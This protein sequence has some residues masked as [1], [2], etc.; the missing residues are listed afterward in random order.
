MFFGN[1]RLN[2]VKKYKIFVI[3]LCFKLFPCFCG[4]KQGLYTCTCAAEF[5]V[6][7]CFVYNLSDDDPMEVEICR[8]VI[9]SDK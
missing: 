1:K 6:S 3:N 5:A 9:V 7:V 2:I 4:Q 8:R